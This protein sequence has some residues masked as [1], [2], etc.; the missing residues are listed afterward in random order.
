MSI[1]EY[2]DYEVETD[3]WGQLFVK[4]TLHSWNL[5]FAVSITGFIAYIYANGEPSASPRR[6]DP[7]C[8]PAEIPTAVRFAKEAE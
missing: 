4:H 8:G 2:V 6:L 1:K 5:H 7:A 3:K